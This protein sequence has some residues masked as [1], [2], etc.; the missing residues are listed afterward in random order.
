MALTASVGRAAAQ[1]IET[2]FALPRFDHSAMDGFGVHA[3]DCNK[4]GLRLRLVGTI[5]AGDTPAA[6]IGPGET[7]RLLTGAA[8]PSGVAAVVMEEHCRARAATVAIDDPV[9]DGLN[10]RRAGEDAGAGAPILAAGEIIG[11]QHIPILAACGIDDLSV[12]RK[13]RIAILST[14]SE[15]VKPGEHA[16]ADLRPRCQRR[17]A[18]RAARPAVD[19]G[20]RF[21]HRSRSPA[22]PGG[23][24]ETRRPVRRCADHV[25]RRFGERRRPCRGGARK[26]PAAAAKSCASR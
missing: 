15:L 13:L 17:A 22:A 19:R 10:I 7:V 18:H 14:G 23:R 4:H 24:D 16:G 6:S 9:T 8:I 2:P 3:G 11:P 20:R 21:W 1:D 5:V 12:R 25:G 26:W